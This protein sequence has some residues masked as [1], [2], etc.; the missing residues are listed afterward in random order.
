MK[1]IH[2][3]RIQERLITVTIDVEITTRD[4]LLGGVTTGLNENGLGA[5]INVMERLNA[6]AKDLQA[7]QACAVMFRSPIYLLLP[8]SG[9]ILRIDDSRDP[10]YQKFIA[11]KFAEDEEGRMDDG[12]RQS[13]REWISHQ[14]DRQQPDES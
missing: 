14:I 8:C 1:R 12:D 3:P 5:R 4:Y 10:A 11:I 7:G 6:K 2:Q 13:V 9:T